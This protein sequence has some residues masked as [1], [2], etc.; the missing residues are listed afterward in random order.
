MN[1]PPFNQS[2][3][4]LIA[5]PFAAAALFFAGI[6]GAP[7]QGDAKA[8]ILRA[9]IGEWME[10][11]SS[12]DKDISEW[13]VQ[14]R[15]LQQT[16][17]GLEGEVASLEESIAAEKEEAG[18]ADEVNVEQSQEKVALVDA[19]D[20][21]KSE[22]ASLQKT[23]FEVYPSLPTPL[24]SDLAEPVRILKDEK[25]DR[26]TVRA[27]AL[28]AALKMVNQFASNISIHPELRE[29]D[30]GTKQ[31]V[32]TIYFGLAGAFSANQSGSFALIGTPSPT[33]WVFESAH[34]FGPSIVQLINVKEGSE[35]IGFVNVPTKISP[36]Q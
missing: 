33:G 35:D 34:E 23:F 31:Q 11:V 14:R 25:E 24:Q 26:L 13:E 5:A 16:I 1:L 9:K 2:H 4:R 19:L 10:K 15:I 20:L 30:D 22:I 17:T 29:I 18:K 27:Q 32:S 28:G 12:I 8:E 21:L 6:G 3:P 7:A 36:K